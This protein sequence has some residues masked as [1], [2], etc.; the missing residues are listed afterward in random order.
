MKKV[1]VYWAAN[2][3][4]TNEMLAFT[5]V[6]D[7]WGIGAQYAKFLIKHGFNTA[8]Q[9]RDAPEEWVRANMTVVG[10]RL[11][12]ELRGIPAI[13]WEFEAPAK[14]NICTA[15]GFGQLLK[16]KHEVSEALAS[17][18]ANCAQKLRIQHSCASTIHVFIETNPFR[19]EDKQYKRSIKMQ[20]PAATNNTAALI[21]SSMKALD[22]IYAEGYNYHKTGITVMELVPE[23]ELQYCIYDELETAKEKTISS[24]LDKLNKSF[25]KDLVRFARQGYSKKWKLMQMKLSP[26]YTTRITD[27][28]K[29]KN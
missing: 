19:R 17:Y 3:N 6:G 25:G 7:V 4:L 12:N 18:A 23:S 9:L 15:R 21:K 11:L 2:V 29:V 8:L 27:I 10:Q 14:K 28:L 16:T 22:I 1:G 5:E 24:T 13:E 26:C 20:L